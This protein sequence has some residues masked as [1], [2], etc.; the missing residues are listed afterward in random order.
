M[1][2]LFCS[3]LLTLTLFTGC[4][5]GD[6][7][8][9]D[10]AT[11]D[12]MPQTYATAATALSQ[13]KDAATVSKLLMDN[14]SAVSDP[15]TGTLNMEASQEFVQ[16]AQELSDKFPAD[17]SAALPLY[18]AAEVVRA[19]NKPAQTAAVYQT[20]YTRYPS[21]SKAPEALFMLGFTYDEDL[22]DLDKA[23]QT[24]T[25]FLQKYPTHSFADDSEMLL[26]NLG[27]SDEEILKELEKNAQQ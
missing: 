8:A 4:G 19:M 23:R 17:T 18:R 26:K 25:D 11:T 14:F 7:S 6:Q 16:L 27:K 21:F 9:S 10:A 1:R 24:Y 22:N 5:N 13:G 20:V 3:Y 15:A 2:Y 12:S